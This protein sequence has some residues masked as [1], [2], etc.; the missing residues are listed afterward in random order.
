MKFQ[1]KL[2]R[3]GGS[4]VHCRLQDLTGSKAEGRGSVPHRKGAWKEHARSILNKKRLPCFLLRERGKE[5]RVQRVVPGGRSLLRNPQGEISPSSG[6]RNRSITLPLSYIISFP[7]PQWSNWHRFIYF[8][9]DITYF[10]FRF[11]LW[12]LYKIQVWDSQPLKS[13]MLKSN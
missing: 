3:D 11:C 7:L 8:S 12:V 13:N 4:M 2:G 10:Y 5:S 9:T 6:R 1:Y